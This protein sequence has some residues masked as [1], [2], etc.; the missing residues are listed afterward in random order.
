MK[1]PKQ[2]TGIKQKRELKTLTYVPMAIQ[3]DIPKVFSEI[4]KVDIPCDG[5]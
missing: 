3:K 2:K 5:D 1:N 4:R